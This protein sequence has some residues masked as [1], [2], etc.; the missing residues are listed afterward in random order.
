MVVTDKIKTSTPSTPFY[1]MAV[2]FI[3]FSSNVLLQTVKPADRPSATKQIYEERC[4]TLPSLSL[5]P[6]KDKII[7]FPKISK[8]NNYSKELSY[9]CSFWIFHL[10]DYFFLSL[11]TV[12]QG[13]RAE[14]YDFETYKLSIYHN[15]LLFSSP[16]TARRKLY[17]SCS[18]SPKQSFLT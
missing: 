9:V 3:M 6:K 13:L 8:F 4:L 5:P 2:T 7:T 10:F 12:Y 11:L 18:R 17:Y 16:S 1:C 14:V 15:I